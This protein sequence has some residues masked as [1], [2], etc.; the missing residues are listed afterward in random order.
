M[1]ACY[2]FCVLLVALCVQYYKKDD[3]GGDEAEVPAGMCA[4]CGQYLP[5]FEA[6]GLG[7]TAS[8]VGAAVGSPD[9]MPTG[10]GDLDFEGGV[11]VGGEGGEAEEEDLDEGGAGAATHP[12]GHHPG[13]A[14][15]GHEDFAAGAG[16]LGFLT[17]SGGGRSLLGPL[18]Q[19]FGRGGAQRTGVR[20]V[21]TAGGD[22]VFSLPCKHNFHALC[23]KGWTLIGKRNSCPCCCAKVELSSIAGRTLLGRQTLFWA[24]LL[25][26]AR[27]LVVWLPAMLALS[28]FFLYEAGVDVQA[29]VH[30]GHTHQGQVGPSPQ[31][32]AGAGGALPP[33]PDGGGGPAA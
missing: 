10:T 12:F 28:R 16:V 20:A 21:R 30:Q 17:P 25:S 24:Q 31:L 19:P 4:L 7:A 15:L 13:A 2:R 9:A 23:I 8:R 27:Y 29:H 5:G 6:A 14:A 32:E 33:R 22:E 3:D 18:V 1:P 11:D 26:L